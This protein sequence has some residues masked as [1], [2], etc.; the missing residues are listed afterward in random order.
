MSDL[1]ER[2]LTAKRGLFDLYYA[3]LNERQREAVYHI[4]D[5]L[6]ILAGAGSG[7]TTVLVR[8]IA[9]I[10][11]YGNAYH[12]DQVPQSL[13]EDHVAALEAAL[14][15]S[16]S[17]KELEELLCEFAN[18]PCP[19]WRVLAIT[20]TNKAA[21]EIKARLAAA[22]PD[23]PDLPSSIWAGTFHSICMRIL[24]RYSAEAGLQPGFTVYDTDDQKK[25]MKTVLSSLNIDEKVLPVKTALNQISRAKDKL[26]SPENF[27]LEAGN[28]YRMKLIEKVYA[29]YQKRLSDSNALDFDD[30]IVR[31]VDLLRTHEDILR[32]YQNQF[33]FVSVD[34]Y[35]DTN[36]AQFRLTELLSGGDRNLMVVGDDDQSIYKFRG[37]TI[38]NILQFTKVFHPATLIRLEQN[39]RST[40]CILDAAN[41]VISHNTKD[42]AM[43][44]TLF[45]DRGEGSKIHVLNPEH[46]NAEARMIVD[47]VQRAVAAGECHYRDFA[48]LFRANAQSNALETAFARSAVPYRMLGGVRFSDRKEIRDI[49][50]Y[51]QLIENH[52]DRERLRRIINEPRRGIGD[53]TLDAIAEIADNEDFSMFEVMERADAYVA[54]SRSAKTLKTFANLIN[55]LTELLSTMELDAFVDEV[56]ERTGYRQMIRDMGQEEAERL[57][58]LDEFISSVKEYMDSVDQ[59]SLSEFLQNTALVA[60]V[61]RYDDNADAV[62]LMTIHS[63]KGLEF[64]RVFLPGFEEGI[65]PGLQTVMAGPE[66]IEEERRLA[67][68]AITRAKDQLYIMHAKSRMLYGHTSCNP[69]SRFLTEIPDRLLDMPRDNA[70]RPHATGVAGYRPPESARQIAAKDPITVGRPTARPTAA[71]QQF[72]AGDRVRHMTF[73]DGLILSVTKMGADTL[74]EIAFDTKGTK[75]LMA[76]YAKLKK[77]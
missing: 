39:Y 50:A 69:A 9:Y 48:V 57:D 30:I 8:R 2:Y 29:A 47:A 64:P 20:F 56:L 42:D 46:Q 38:E 74:Y 37:A 66:E 15:S 68:V 63:A 76:T 26:I 4:M 34:E 16:P 25:A 54:L 62:V 14:L 71:L 53:K 23:D 19:P 60:D 13:T 22:F 5:P 70:P 65:F 28:D 77:I 75:K 44:K 27:L 3:S 51:L 21:N 45:T 35:Q 24:R 33:R 41:A 73:G 40:Q 10:I 32:S 6:L 49:V 58:N 61:D 31:T 67:Y 52:R 12:S 59:P 43:R 55:E 7:K 17:Q 1:K 18:D 36:Q 11:R 72:A